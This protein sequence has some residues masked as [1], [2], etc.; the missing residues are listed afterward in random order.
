MFPFLSDLINYLFGFSF[1]FPLPMFGFM[2]ALAFIAANLLFVK[3]MKR[4]EADGLLSSSIINVMKGQ[5]A[6]LNDLIGNGIFGFVVGYKIGGIILN[7]Q[8]AI[9]D[10]PDYVLSL[11]GNFLSGLAIAVVL[12]YLKYRD[13]EKQRLPEPKEVTEVV[14]PYQH[15]GNMTFIAAIGGILGAK[16]FDAVEDLERFAADPIGVLFSG[17]GLSIYGGLIIGGGAVVYY[18]HKKGLKLVH[19]IDACA[20]G[21]ML[22]YGIGRIGCQLSGDGDWGTTN[23]LPMPEALSFL[24]EW[25][26]SFTYPHNVNADGI[27]IAGCEGKYCYELPIPVWPTPFYETIMAFIIFAGLW[28]FRKKITIPGLMFSIYLIFNGI[29]RFFIEKIRINPDYN[30][31]GMKATQA[32]L[33]AIVLFLVGVAGAFYV[34][35][36]NRTN[37]H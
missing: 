27:L 13:A 18:A 3:E 17:S 28:L 34:V 35:Q 30:I 15:V 11:Q 14:R 32:E 10:L 26:W 1:S 8:Q 29:E 16:L 2:V 6:S 7:Y 22:A 19:V 5:K 20:P 31:F 33:I 12:A 9:E 23:E 36:K 24:P 37:D 25:M 21:L 4:K